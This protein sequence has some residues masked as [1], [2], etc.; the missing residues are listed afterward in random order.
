MI[1]AAAVAFEL[2]EG[3]RHA[4]LTDREHLHV[5]AQRNLAPLGVVGARILVGEDL[6]MP[7]DTQLVHDVV[8]HLLDRPDT[9]G[10]RRRLVVHPQQARGPLARGLEAGPQRLGSSD[11]I[12]VDTPVREPS[13]RLVR[14]RHRASTL[15]AGPARPARR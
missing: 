14:E 4:A 7:G 3:H 9:A 5:P 6:P 10:R 12:E 11:E 2:G 15:I 13:Q 8:G 1:S